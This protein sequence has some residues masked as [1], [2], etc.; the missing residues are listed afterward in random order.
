MTPSVNLLP[1]SYRQT[2]ARRHRFRLWLAVGAAL[3]GAELFAGF[4]LHAHAG[5]TREMLDAAQ[6]ARTAT[7]QVKKRMET[8]AAES[9]ALAQQL[10]LAKKLRT[11]HYWSRLFGQLT[12]A[13]S[14]GVTLTAISTDPARWSA[15][16]DADAGTNATGK[17]GAPAPALLTGLTVRGF[18][19]DYEE[20]AAFVKGVQNANAFASLNLREARR[21]KYLEQEVVSF[22]LQCRW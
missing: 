4:L 20:L 8:P 16:L 11:T 14:S 12:V 19:T 1:Q 2:Q 3:L 22:E 5:R 17:S 7:G 18:A 21:D 15:V 13:A 10:A 6:A 9:K